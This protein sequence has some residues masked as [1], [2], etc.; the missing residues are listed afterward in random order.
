MKSTPP[1]LPWLQYSTQWRPCFFMRVI[2]FMK[3]IDGAGIC[4]YL[5][6]TEP[7]ELVKHSDYSVASTHASEHAGEYGT[8]HAISPR[9][10]ASFYSHNARIWIPPWNLASHNPPT[11]I[12]HGPKLQINIQTVSTA[13]F[14][15]EKVFG[16]TIP[17]SAEVLKKTPIIHQ[18]PTEVIY[19]QII[20]WALLLLY[21]IICLHSPLAST[22]EQLGHYSCIH[23]LLLYCKACGGA[24]TAP[25]TYQV[26]PERYRRADFTLH[27]GSSKRD[28]VNY[29]C[30][31]C[32][33]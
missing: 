13:D 5:N 7:A 15:Q 21:C 1:P 24:L 28:A 18:M 26:V 10:F 16:C 31:C 12:T 14:R 19:T 2:L 9:A 8:G 25:S 23:G 17:T 32:M 33:S 29:Y 27:K 20:T 30:C 4:V 3:S 22:L 6:L 11:W